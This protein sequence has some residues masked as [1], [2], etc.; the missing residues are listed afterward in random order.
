MHTP[1][2]QNMFPICVHLLIRWGLRTLI[3]RNESYKGCNQIPSPIAAY[4][5]LGMQNEGFVYVLVYLSVFLSFLN[6]SFNWFVVA[7]CQFRIF[8]SFIVFFVFW[9]NPEFE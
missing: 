1:T 3:F 9:E 4:G 7:L 5:R 6:L 8:S 2:A